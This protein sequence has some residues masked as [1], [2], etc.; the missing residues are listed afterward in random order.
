[1]ELRHCPENRY[2]EVA[3]RVKVGVVIAAE[4]FSVDFEVE[5]LN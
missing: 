4:A 3:D 5:L 2:G 1:M